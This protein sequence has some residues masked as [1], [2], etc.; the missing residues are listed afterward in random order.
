MED[1]GNICQL[2]R[3]KEYP[4]P[5]GLTSNQWLSVETLLLRANKI[6]LE[7]IKKKVEKQLR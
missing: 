6:Q 3:R 4:K 5:N 1:I 2:S 7:L